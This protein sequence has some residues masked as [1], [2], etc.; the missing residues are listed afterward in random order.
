MKRL[1]VSLLYF[2]GLFPLLS[3][4]QGFLRNSDLGLD[5]G[6]MT[7][8]GDLNNQSVFGTPHFAYGVNYRYRFDERWA[9]GVTAAKGAMSGGNPD[10]NPT[11][12]LN[13]TSPVYEANV[14]AEFNFRKFDA[15]SPAYNW[16]TFI[17]VGLGGLYFNP[18]TQYTD[19]VDGTVSWVELQPLGTEGQMIR[20]IADRH[21]YSR[22]QMTM[23]FGLGAKF[24]LSEIVVVTAEYGFRKTWTDYLDD[25]STTYVDRSLF[26]TTEEGQLA[27]ELADRTSEVIPGYENAPG[28]K[29]G[30]DSLDDW[31][32]YA[33]VSLSVNMD[34]LFGWLRKPKCNDNNN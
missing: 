29:R 12:N 33:K 21:K 13:F 18:M 11:R 1:V 7:Y 28:D 10:C 19:P 15:V 17:F 5:C 20:A 3:H 24:R 4:A 26:P 31:Y 16:T 30:D 6:F 32:T 8:I 14:R 9:L 27:A 23:P 25:V 34:F 22:F 2:V